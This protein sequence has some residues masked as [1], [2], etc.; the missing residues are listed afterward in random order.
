MNTEPDITIHKRREEQRV[1]KPAGVEEQLRHWN[2]LTQLLTRKDVAELDAIIGAGE[3]VHRIVRGIYQGGRGVLVATNSR[4]VFVAK[5]WFG[6]SRVES[7]LYDELTSVRYAPYIIYGGV[8]IV[9]RGDE[10]IIRTIGRGDT[11]AFREYVTSRITSPL[12]LAPSRGHIPPQVKENV[13]T[14]IER[15]AELK[16]QDVL[17]EEEMQ[18][19]KRELLRSWFDGQVN[20]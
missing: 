7:F 8:A 12:T 18:E 1:Q 16:K 9:A 4:I 11:R 10:V 3:I 13:I 2:R 14:Q 5:E 19:Q 6:R 15:L 20:A 17:T